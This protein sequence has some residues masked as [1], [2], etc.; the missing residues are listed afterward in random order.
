MKD[1][2][3]LAI[4]LNIENLGNANEIM[5]ALSTEC[6][7]LDLVELNMPN[8]R[9]YRLYSKRAVR[10]IITSALLIHEEGQASKVSAFLLKEATIEEAATRRLLKIR[11]FFQEVE[12]ARIIDATTEEIE[13]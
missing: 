10:L 12:E 9:S 5:E 7:Y 1:Q 2:K 11:N 8:G 13:H 3:C 6:D 4:Q